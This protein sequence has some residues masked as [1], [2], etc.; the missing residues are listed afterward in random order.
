VTTTATLN[1][2]ATAVP[3]HDGHDAF[4]RFARG[5]LDDPR[6]RAVF[7]RLAIKAQIGHRFSFLAPAKNPDGDAID[8]QRIYT[9]GKFP[10]TGQRMMLYEKH[11][12]TLA[13]SAF[14]KLELGADAK[15]ITHVIV[16]SCTGFM[17][18]GIDLELVD[19]CGLNPSV[20][21]TT[22]GF[23]G[24][25]AAINGLKLARHIVRSEPTSQVLMIN[26]ELCSLHLQEAKSIEQMLS[27]LVFGDG[28][29]ASI[30]SADPHGLAL[31]RFHAALVPDTKQLITWK[32]RD[33]GFDMF[34]SGK[35]PAAISHGL[36]VV[37]NEILDG[38]SASEMDLWAV[39]PGGRSVLDAVENGMGL[40]SDALAASRDVLNRFGN[41]SSATVMFVLE[42][43]LKSSKRG[44][45]GCAMSFG[46][47]LTAET[48]LFHRN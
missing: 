44:E 42:S 46:P 48:M 24:C 12:P 14:D 5:L 6:A 3:P 22:V 47:G 19:R 32:I 20:E 37:T 1:R 34:L 45:R 23:M 9:R 27:F 38:A 35:V 7:D 36:N 2:I 16:T 39:H 13:V 21:R 15:K 33:V 28:C 40:S 41:M 8:E 25:Y 4:I 30:I 10:T 26:L 11:A 31:D 17:A 43:I 29:A 18:P